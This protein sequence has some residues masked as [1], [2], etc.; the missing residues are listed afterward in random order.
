M[1]RTPQ[2][3]LDRIAG[4]TTSEHEYLAI[5]G[6]TIALTA[7]QIKQGKYN[8]AWRAA[9]AHAEAYHALKALPA[10]CHRWDRDAAV[11]KLNDAEEALADA[12]L[13]NRVLKAP[14]CQDCRCKIDNT[15]ELHKQDQRAGSRCPLCYQHYLK[16]KQYNNPIQRAQSKVADLAASKKPKQSKHCPKCHHLRHKKQFITFNDP[17]GSCELCRNDEWNAHRAANRS[18][19]LGVAIA[20]YLTKE[21]TK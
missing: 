10:R 14:R 11:A 1:K 6:Y 5:T 20:N 7:A 18:K 15:K 3:M 4:L 9:K 19:G 2:Y 13:Q 16:R 17:Y 21:K 12:R 8:N